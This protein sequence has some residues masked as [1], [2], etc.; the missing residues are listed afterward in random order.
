MR[1]QRADRHHDSHELRGSGV[2]RH[3]RHPRHLTRPG[4]MIRKEEA[5]A[6]LPPP[7]SPATEAP[8]A[9]RWILSAPGKSS[10]GQPLFQ[11]ARDAAHNLSI[12][13]STVEPICR[14]HLVYGPHAHERE[15]R[16]D[17]LFRGEAQEGEEADAGE[18]A[19]DKGRASQAD[20][21]AVGGNRGMAPEGRPG[22]LPIPRDTGQHGNLGGIS[23]PA[24]TPLAACHQSTK[25]ATPAEMDA[26][27]GAL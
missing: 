14:N 5:G 3:R 19:G 8:E 6:S 15:E 4:A 12:S 25:P 20:A 18:V 27:M 22:L 9:V 11:P 16:K 7:H 1:R 17:G 24:P 26:P 2:H 23:P 21:R 10:Q 13:L